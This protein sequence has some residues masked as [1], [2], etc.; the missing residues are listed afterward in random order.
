ML[1]NTINES[2]TTN[3]TEKTA[4]SGFKRENF[5]RTLRE[6]IMKIEKLPLENSFA[7]DQSNLYNKLVDHLELEKQ[8][9]LTLNLNASMG[10][11]FEASLINKTYTE[12]EE[13]SFVKF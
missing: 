12:G 9:K 6:E 10:G 5:F 7:F 4:I 3:F 2:F 11:S 8:K 1:D 13:E